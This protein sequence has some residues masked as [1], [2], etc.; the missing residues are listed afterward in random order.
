MLPFTFLLN[1]GGNCAL[2][3]FVRLENPYGAGRLSQI[4]R[5]FSGHPSLHSLDKK[6]VLNTRNEKKIKAKYVPRL[7]IRYACIWSLPCRKPA[8]ILLQNNFFWASN[9]F[10]CKRPKLLNFFIVETC[11]AK[12]GKKQQFNTLR[13]LGLVW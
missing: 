5:S 13:P 1:F 3:N 10:L 4:L 12:Y 8:L 2:F 9:Y 7:H 6:K 11:S